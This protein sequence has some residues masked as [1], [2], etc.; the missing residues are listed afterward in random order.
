MEEEEVDERTEGE[1]CRL[2]IGNLRTRCATSRWWY[3]DDHEVC[4]PL[5]MRYDVSTTLEWNRGII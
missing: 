1:E 2:D 4:G 3:V 5:D